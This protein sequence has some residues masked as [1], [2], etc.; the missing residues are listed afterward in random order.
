MKTALAISSSSQGELAGQLAAERALSQLAEPDVGVLFTPAHFSQEEVHAGARRVL[1]DILLVGGS[2]IHQVSNLGKTEGC[3]V[4]LLMAAEELSF[5]LSS[6]S[7]DQSP[8]E[9]L[10]ALAAPFHFSSDTNAGDSTALFFA[11]PGAL[12]GH[13]FAEQLNKAFAQPLPF[14]GGGVLPSDRESENGTKESAAVFLNDSVLRNHLALLKIEASQSDSFRF[15]YSYASCWSAVAPPVRVTRAEGRK[16]FE[17]DH[18]PIYEYLKGYLGADF[19]KALK[20]TS[21]KYT[22]LARLPDPKG[23][24]FV[25][26]TPDWSSLDTGISFY[27]N[28]DMENLELQLVQVSRSELLN[29]AERAA[30]S[31]LKALDGYKPEAV[32]MFSCRTRHKFLHSRANDEVLRVRKV[33]GDHVPLIGFYA[34][35][36]Y[37]PVYAQHQD[38]IDP[39]NAYAGSQNLSTSVCLLAIGSPQGAPEETS[40]SAQ[41]R[42]HIQDDRLRECR[43]E[44]Y[45]RRIAELIELLRHSEEMIDETESAF[46]HI[47]RE[48]FQLAEKLKAKN[49][50]LASSNRRGERL[51][52]IIRQ[53]TPRNVWKKAH[54]SVDAGFYTIPDE[55]LSPT[56]MFLDVKGFTAFAE[57][58]SS[59]EVIQEI[60][61]IFEPATTIIYDRGGD[62]DKY[63]GDCIFAIFDSSLEAVEAA[64]EIQTLC[65]MEHSRGSPFSVRIGLNR[66]RVIAGNVGGTHRRDNTMI[67]DAV[68]LTQRLEAACKPGY[69]L[70]SGELYRS[71]KEDLPD[72][73]SVTRREI[74]VKGKE[75]PVEAFEICLEKP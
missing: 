62:V 17:V 56:L 16:V 5:Q 2:A 49:K 45:Q 53:Y 15:G 73:L 9:A 14:S 44:D 63:I 19:V 35:G 6:T 64:L 51:Q 12:A 29:G 71:I 43:P 24:H 27:P 59:K 74:S 10:S 31:A 55:E 75:L 1:G 69:V 36:E 3:V 65:R 37:S 32:F 39:E 67:G 60:N 23:D 18:T 25:I 13:Q 58:H 50:E 22:F 7:Q 57:K 11:S 68:N 41:L 28:C 33:F 70:L 52:K 26:R 40:F 8:E 21:W 46:K 38:A 4:L 54:I 66:G 20:T 47:N 42:K 48:H 34:G 61:K 30:K 72:D